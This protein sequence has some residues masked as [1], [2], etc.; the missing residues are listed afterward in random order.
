MV[1]V[2]ELF[3][4]ILGNPFLLIIVIGGIVS[5]LKGK[6]GDKEKESQPAQRSPK[7]APVA[8]P[9]DRQ[10]QRNYNQ[11]KDENKQ[12]PIHTLSMED[13]REKQIERLAGHIQTTSE[14]EHSGLKNR[15]KV[16]DARR[17]EEI[18][19]LASSYDQKKFKKDFKTSL[20]SKGLINSVV[21]AE[22]LGSPR[23]RKPYQSVIKNR[24]TPSR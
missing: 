18:K 21:M 16:A 23:S 2:D 1:L 8:Q 19:Q 15:P 3:K 10:V 14:P 5:L 12:E 17:L 20:T 9:F 6:S 13:Q 24:Q 22:V 7:P 4:A 11:T